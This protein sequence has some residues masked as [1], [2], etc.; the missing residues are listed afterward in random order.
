M[1]QAESVLR[2]ALDQQWSEELVL[3]YGHAYGENL[4]E[5]LV[6]A[7][8]WFGAHPDDASLLLSCGRLA[9]RANDLSKARTY[10]EKSANLGG[11]IDAFAELGALLERSGEKDRALSFYRRGLEQSASDRSPARRGSG[12]G[13]RYRL[14]GKS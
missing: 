6:H 7:E 11:P 1:K 10:L 4:G 3:L 5:Q 12:M 8:S 9:L 13:A 2:T 14:V